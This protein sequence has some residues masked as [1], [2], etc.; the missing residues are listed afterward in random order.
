M[1]NY[2]KG[3]YFKTQDNSNTVSIIPAIHIDKF[4]NESTTIQVITNNGSWCTSTPFSHSVF[5]K[6]RPVSI[7]DNNT[8]CE[9]GLK[10][11][12]SENNLRILGKLNFGKLCSIKHDIMGPFRYIPFMQCRHSVYS[13]THSVNGYLYIN[14]DYYEFNDAKGYIEGDRGYS[15]PKNYIWT[16]CNFD[17]NSLMLSVAD[18]PL[19][20][21]KFTGTIGVVLF[22]GKQYRIATYLGAKVEYVK[23]NT[24]IVRQGNSTIIAKLIK[25]SP[26]ALYAPVNGSMTRTI[27][28]SAQCTVFYCFMLNNKKIFEFQ[29]NQAAFE[30][31]YCK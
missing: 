8:F 21:T 15:F 20:G 3:Y 28:E 4:G 29:T 6:S 11:N 2:F 1:S 14:D 23:N 7:I 26:Q 30:Y 10:L 16:Q 18:I 22:N 19:L 13:M 9:R 27:N 25:N 12:I 31:E 24:V 5:H 17:N